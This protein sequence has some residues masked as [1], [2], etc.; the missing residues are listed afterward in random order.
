MSAKQDQIDWHKTRTVADVKA[1]QRE[2]G[3][4][5]FEPGAIRFFRT[6][7]HTSELIHG[8]YFVTSE[9]FD[10]ASPRLYSVRMVKP[11]FGINTVG[12][13]QGYKTL[14]EANRAAVYAPSRKEK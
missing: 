3:M 4:H 6:K 11:N 13:F 9:Q 14:T 10:D 5:W 8:R 7:I 12:K 2:R 1:R